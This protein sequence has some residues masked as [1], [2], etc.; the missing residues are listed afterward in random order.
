MQ[1]TQLT[2]H[3]CCNAQLVTELIHTVHAC[4]CTLQNSTRQLI[5]QMAPQTVAIQVSLQ[6]ILGLHSSSES[7]WGWPQKHGMF[8]SDAAFAEGPAN[9]TANCTAPILA[10]DPASSALL[11]TWRRRTGEQNADVPVVSHGMILIGSTG[12]PTVAQS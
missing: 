3:G 11:E 9:S 5:T 4:S 12:V 8:C 6:K 7:S 10:L 1:C 2:F